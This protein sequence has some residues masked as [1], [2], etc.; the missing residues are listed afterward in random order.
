MIDG[1]SVYMD[2]WDKQRWIHLRPKGGERTNFSEKIQRAWTIL[3]CEDIHRIGSYPSKRFHS[4]LSIYLYRKCWWRLCEC[5][6]ERFSRE[7]MCTLGL[8][9]QHT[10]SN[11]RPVESTVESSH[12][13]RE[14][15]VWYRSHDRWNSVLISPRDVSVEC[16]VLNIDRHW[17]SR[18]TQTDVLFQ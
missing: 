6:R 3:L 13:D 7:N 2:G 12:S 9:R 10:K 17:S 16:D 14:C 11:D 15:R 18:T 8:G 1:A 4:I 5:E